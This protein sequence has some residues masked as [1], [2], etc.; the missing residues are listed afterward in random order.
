M[1]FSPGNRFSRP[2]MAQIDLAALRHNLARCQ[3][4]ANGNRLLAVVKANA[5]G[6]GAV[7]IA[8]QLAQCGVDFFGGV[9]E[10]RAGLGERSVESRG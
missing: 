2:T 8:Q 3:S 10:Y 1:A 7:P 9:E 6:H 4:L 5:Y